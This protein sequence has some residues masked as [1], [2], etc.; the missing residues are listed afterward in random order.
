MRK[1]THTLTL[2]TAR[3]TNDDDVYIY[4]DLNETMRKC[5]INAHT[6]HSMKIHKIER[7]KQSN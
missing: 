1:Y 6:E 2:P 3:S 4:T 5:Y 7:Q